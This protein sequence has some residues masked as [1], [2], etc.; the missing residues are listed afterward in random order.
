MKKSIL[1]HIILSVLTAVCLLPAFGDVLPEHAETS[2]F[3]STTGVVRGFPN[4]E[5]T[6]LPSGRQRTLYW[7]AAIAASPPPVRTGA[8]Q[9][10]KSTGNVAQRLSAPPASPNRPIEDKW[11]IVVGISSFKD[12]SIHPLTY[13]SKDARDFY[14]YLVKEANFAPD[15]VRLLLDD[16]ADQRRI[17]SEVG[18]KFLARLVHRDDLVVIF[19]STHGSPS[20][21]D[22]KKKNFLV[23]YDSDPT[24]LFTT[25]IEM[26]SIFE[27]IQRRVSTERI[28]LV[29]DACHSGATDTGAKGMGRSGNFDAQELAQGSGR[30]VIC[31]SQRQEQSFESKRYDNGVF[32]RQLLKGL[33][34]A[35]SRT[36]LGQAFNF[37]EKA[38][39]E[40]VRQDYPDASQTPS[41]HGKWSGNDL[42]LSAHP[43]APRLVPPTVQEDLKPDSTENLP[44]S[45][46]L[47]PVAST[48]PPAVSPDIAPYA[49]KTRTIEPAAP[50]IPPE[51]GAVSPM[52]K[53]KWALLIGVGKFSDPE[54]PALRYAAKD[55][56][57]FY[58]YLVTQGN[59]PKDQVLLLTDE[60]AARAQILDVV[61]EKLPRLIDPDDLFLVYISSHCSSMETGNSL[62]TYDTSCAR[63]FSTAIPMSDLSLIISTR[64]KAQRT[65]MILDGVSRETGGSISGADRTGPI[66]ASERIYAKDL[67]PAYYM[68]QGTGIIILCANGPGQHAWESKRY[69]NSVFTHQLIE[70]FLSKGA[71]TSVNEAFSYARAR[72]DQE[73]W[74]DRGCHQTPLI[75]SKWIGGDLHPFIKI[76]L[77]K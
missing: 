41:K 60:K 73:V 55:A 38:V 37:V 72:V 59:F 39:P 42:I 5:A 31:S 16:K 1:L 29:L 3:P 74:Q 69:P 2:N 36:T 25:G 68:S 19:L 61:N 6:V 47:P 63:I 65:L 40:E 53:K 75:K 71:E 52:F 77:V 54:I 9:G 58:Q 22:I 18:S 8:A 4:L 34:L 11:A 26:Q 50:E 13:A 62:I 33:H 10:K 20:Q 35:G 44:A 45:A 28:L 57:D 23:A 32:T 21:F 49:I 56:K 66:A 24:D 46:T 30:L 15:H 14:T 48:V 70:G 51:S 67:M 7:Q 64:I 76:P 43:V 12:P 17:L 27:S